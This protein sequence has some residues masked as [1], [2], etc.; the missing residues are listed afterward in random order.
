[1]PR[2]ASVPTFK[3]AYLIHGDD[4]G[5][6]GERRAR[7]RAIAEQEGGASGAEVFEGEEATPEAIGAALSAMTFATGRRFLIVDGAERWKDKEIEALIAPALRA[8]PPDTTVAFF[9]REEGRMKVPGKLSAAVEKA[10][11]DV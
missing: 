7:L 4:H 10:G 2:L 1:M 3:S 9:A 8:M 11:G 6:I 5:R